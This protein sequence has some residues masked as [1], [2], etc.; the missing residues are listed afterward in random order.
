MALFGDAVVPIADPRP[1]HYVR[2]AMSQSMSGLDW[3][4]LDNDMRD[5]HSGKLQDE[6]VKAALWDYWRDKPFEM[7]DAELMAKVEKSKVNKFDT[8]LKCMPG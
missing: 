2:S 1:E 4:G 8:L 5:F 3:R 6:A 7:G